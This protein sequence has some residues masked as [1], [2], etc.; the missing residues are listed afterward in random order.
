MTSGLVKAEVYTLSNG[1]AYE[2]TGDGLGF[3]FM[4]VIQAKPQVTQTTKIPNF[5][6]ILWTTK[7]DLVR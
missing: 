5:G 4:G 2:E 1:V 6:E 3:Q 7:E